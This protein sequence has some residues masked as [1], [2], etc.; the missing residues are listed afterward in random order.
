[1]IGIIFLT[2]LIFESSTLAQP[3]S[4]RIEYDRTVYWTRILDELSYLNQE[5]KDRT[6][7]AWGKEDGYTTQMELLWNGQKSVYQMSGDQKEKN[8]QWSWRTEE[9]HYFEDR[10]LNMRQDIVEMPDRVYRVEDKIPVYRWKILSDIKQVQGYLCMSAETFDS[11]RSHRIVAWF[12]TEIPVP[13]GPERYG[14]LP[15]VI[16]ELEIQN[17][18]CVITANS[19]KLDTIFQLSQAPKS[20]KLKVINSARLSHLQSEYIKQC[21]VGRRNPYWNLRY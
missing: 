15:G 13:I 8:N 14:G 21:V 17:G 19:V 3:L 18:A 1:M 10:E 16:L 7:F 12:S 9:L 20:K 6:K 2:F 4:G 11:V 5:E